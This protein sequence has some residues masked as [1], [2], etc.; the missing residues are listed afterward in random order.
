MGNTD[1]NY[2][3]LVISSDKYS[4][5]WPTFFTCFKNNWP[6]CN[7]PV[8]LGSNTTEYEN[9]LGVITIL[10]GKDLD[11][12]SSLKKILKEVKEDYL[13]VIL[14]D[15]LIISKVN[16]EEIIECFNYM[17]NNNINHMHDMNLGM[18]Y[19]NE[20]DNNYGQYMT[21]APYR[22]NVFGFWNKL[23]LMSIL[24]EGESPWEFEI[25]GSYRSKTWDNFIA[26]KEP[27]FL[28]LNLVEKGCYTK[29]SFD[30]CKKNNIN[31]SSNRSIWLRQNKIIKILQVFYFNC[32][33][34]IP[35]KTRLKIM[36]KI[37]KLLITY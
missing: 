15:F 28:I 16:E 5:I 32:M 21:G 12:S 14:E 18:K 33:K 20:V 6:E 11:W 34:R 7:I 8:Y 4:D 1:K 29:K 9:S 22:A 24:Q 13:F 23:C 17:I 19:D 3:I 25:M 36:N 10:S 26:L 27:P 31:I 2:A 35:W 37:R 30:Y